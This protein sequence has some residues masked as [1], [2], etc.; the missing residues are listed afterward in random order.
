MTSYTVHQVSVTKK[1]YHQQNIICCFHIGPTI[2]GTA[3]RPT[4]I[5][6]CLTPSTCLSIPLPRS[7]THTDSLTIS[8]SGLDA[9]FHLTRWWELHPY[10]WPRY[11]NHKLQKNFFVIVKA[12]QFSLMYSISPNRTRHTQYIHISLD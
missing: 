6:I 11:I 2:H 8:N 10:V 4:N 7:F 9:S 1:R 3:G 5:N 12:K